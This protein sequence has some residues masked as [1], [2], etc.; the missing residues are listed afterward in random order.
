ML[1]ENKAL[2]IRYYFK[3]ITK[4]SPFFI[5]KKIILLIYII[6]YYYDY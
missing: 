3:K 5:Q 1:K 4:L 6:L 2:T